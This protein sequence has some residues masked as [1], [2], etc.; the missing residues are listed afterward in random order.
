MGHLGSHCSLSGK[1]NMDVKIVQRPHQTILGQL[2][3]RWPLSDKTNTDVKSVQDHFG[4]LGGRQPVSDKT[5]MHI[6][7]VRLVW[8]VLDWTGLD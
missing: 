5:N 3:G 6:K 1:T 2:G 7:S 8:A 4:Y